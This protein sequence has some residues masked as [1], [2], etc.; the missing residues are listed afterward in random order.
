M[1]RKREKQGGHWPAKTVTQTHVGAHVCTHRHVHGLAHMHTHVHIHV[2]WTRREER[3][4]P[5]MAGPLAQGPCRVGVCSPAQRLRQKL[6][7]WVPCWLP[8]AR[9]ALGRGGC[10]G[11]QRGS[12]WL[13]VRELG[14]ASTSPPDVTSCLRPAVVAQRYGNGLPGA[15]VEGTPRGPGSPPGNGPRAGGPQS[16]AQT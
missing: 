6:L 4:R 16:E 11:C 13:R 8:R 12:E 10:P 3:P 2:P 15:S 1:G 7:F 9:A 14:E 5:L